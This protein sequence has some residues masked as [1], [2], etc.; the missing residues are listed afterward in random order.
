MTGWILLFFAALFF[1]S[2]T[3]PGQQDSVSSL[4]DTHNQLDI[5][6]IRRSQASLAESPG[7]SLRSRDEGQISL[8]SISGVPKPLQ[9]LVVDSEFDLI[10]SMDTVRSLYGF[11]T[12]ESLVF[13]KRNALR[14]TT[15]YEFQEHIGGIPTR[16]YLDVLV[17]N[18]TNLIVS[19]SGNLVMDRDFVA[20]HDLT[21]NEAI[22]VVLDFIA[23]NENANEY[24][25][26]GRHFAEL[27]YLEWNDGSPTLS[28]HWMASIQLN[29]GQEPEEVFQTFIVNPLSEVTRGDIYL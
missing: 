29:N 2:G 3:S 11:G 27:D 13:R 21:A 28:P 16:Y 9:E 20:Q 5:Q 8:T 12:H 10:S 1:G 14:E 15:T 17:N 22:L 25:V 24:E 23:L 18:E 6:A 26:T 4:S 7:V 19:L